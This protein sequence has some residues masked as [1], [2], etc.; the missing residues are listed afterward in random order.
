MAPAFAGLFAMLAGVTLQ[1]DG[2]SSF[3]I[4][5]QKAE[6]IVDAHV[7]LTV[8]NRGEQQ[9][10]LVNCDEDV[11]VP[12][13]GNAS[14]TMTGKFAFWV[15]PTGLEWNCN[16]GPFDLFAVGADLTGPDLKLGVGVNVVPDD[17]KKEGG[18]QEE[19][20]DNDNDDDD[21]DEDDA[22]DNNDAKLDTE[23]QAVLDEHNALRAK[24]SAP[25]LTWDEAMASEA[26]SWA[27]KCAWGHSN[28]PGENIW[29]GSGSAF[30]GAAAVKSWYNE[31][32]NPGYN[33]SSPGTSEGTG[34]FTAVVW[35]STTRLGCAMKVCTPLHPMDWN[36][37]NFLVCQYSPAGNYPGGYAAN[38]LAK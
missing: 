36:P 18:G 14:L 19:Q 5:G 11:I 22:D 33:F 3:N 28:A 15:V 26:Q 35:K 12:A 1:G 9:I 29:A 10:R 21:N 32:T 8:H 6:Q 38:V 25:D 7:P 24:H 31:L 20:H 34:H 17:H 4:R 37:G 16:T 13:E 27:D 30:S 2:W 23:M